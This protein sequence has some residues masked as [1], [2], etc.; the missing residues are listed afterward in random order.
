[1]RH[2]IKKKPRGGKRLGKG[3]HGE[4]FNVGEIYGEPSF[5]SLIE[6]RNIE[7]IEIYSPESD[8]HQIHTSES[9]LTQF[10][11]YIRI[12]PNRIAKIFLPAKNI[13]EDFL[14]EIAINR[15]ITQIYGTYAN[16]YLTIGPMPPTFRNEMLG[17]IIT[18]NNSEKLYTVFNS[19]CNNHYDITD[20]YKFANDILDS[21]II[22]QT[23]SYEHN[24]IKLDNIVKCDDTYKLIDWGQAATVLNPEKKVGSLLSTSPI[25]WYILGHSHFNSKYRMQLRTTLRNVRFSTSELFRTTFFK[26]VTEYNTVTEATPDRTTL[27]KKYRYTF[28]IFMLGMTML[29]AVYKYRLSAEMYLPIINKF[30]SLLDPVKNAIEAKEFLR[31]HMQEQS[32]SQSA[33]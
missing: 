30:T 19:K 31:T 1:M 4:A 29:H 32:Q 25:R 14:K 12:I 23:Q 27:A 21:I 10:K 2:T 16:S 33:A 22:L 6:E 18:F 5:F 20:L 13:E 3:A 15:K 8:E 17:C 11:E 7:K 9:D 24:D 28:D 26:I